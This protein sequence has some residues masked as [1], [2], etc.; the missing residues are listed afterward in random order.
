MIRVKIQKRSKHIKSNNNRHWIKIDNENCINNYFNMCCH[1]EVVI[2]EVV[3][4]MQAVMTTTA[5]TATSTIVSTTT[6]TA[7]TSNK[8]VT[9]L[10]PPFLV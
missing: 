9:H 5:A 2:A 8:V 7:T 10:W 6:T 3:Y 4:L 1:A